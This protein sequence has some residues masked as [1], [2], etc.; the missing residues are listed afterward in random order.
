MGL[1]MHLSKKNYVKNWGHMNPDEKY[2]ITVKQG[3]KSISKK[4]IDT[5]KIDYI[6]Q[7]VGYW[8]KANA[9]HQWFVE[10]VQDGVDDCKA[11]Y[12]S[13]EKLQELL[14][15]VNKVIGASGLVDGN[16]H[17][18]TVYQD[19][20]SIPVLE[21]GKIVKDPTV[22]EELLP[23]QSGF[24]FGG[25]DYDQWYY[26]DLVETKRILEEALADPNGE[27]YYQSSW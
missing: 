7:E 22:A 1:D 10:N 24:F 21:D 16:V 17:N 18:G 8:R 25:T 3:G 11:Y 14:D 23:T 12:V 9:V 13:T 20:K 27:Y 6:I 4:Q 26:D 5:A 15:T 19:G 2:S